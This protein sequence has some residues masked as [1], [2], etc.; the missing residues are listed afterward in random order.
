MRQWSRLRHLAGRLLAGSDGRPVTDEAIYLTETAYRNHQPRAAKAPEIRERHF[1]ADLR[2]GNR[3]GKTMD[4]AAA[5]APPRRGLLAR[6]G[7][8]RRLPAA[9][10][11]HGY[12]GTKILGTPHPA[13]KPEAA[14]KPEAEARPPA[15]S[16]HPAAATKPPTPGPATPPL[17]GDPPASGAPAP[18]GPQ[19]A[20]DPGD[21][22]KRKAPPS[23]A[24][25]ERTQPGDAELLDSLFG[26]P[27]EAPP[28]KPARP[29]APAPVK[30]PSAPA[31]A[32]TPA[33][34]SPAPARTGKKKKKKMDRGD[35]T[36]AVLGA[37]LAVT[38]ALFPW[39]IF[40]NQEKFG[41]RE[42]V[43]SG[44]GTARPTPGVAY[45][46][47]YI[48]KPFANAEVPKMELDFFPTATLPSGQEPVRAV[49]A[50]EQPF[51][52]DRVAFRLIHV[53]N[54]RAMIE[55]SDGLWV[56]QR[57]SQLP[58]ASR[59]AAIEQR[60][61]RWVLVTSDDRVVELAD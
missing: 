44:G 19:A 15:G 16:R 43:F 47:Q 33:K 55:D 23:P 36:M 46:P 6:L 13:C 26:K 53:A 5:H 42:F 57:G 56:V 50:S 8:G 10:G 12:F 24:K 7:I 17:A 31:S 1:G 11:E 30:Q 28:P 45:Q 59:V 9:A 21:G 29:A 27:D 4:E 3:G 41:V 35:V 34:P 54:G 32:A 25:S 20:T 39:Y 2:R 40:F 38:C 49:P 48:G 22:K 61:G 60:E 18:A 52:A 37:T 51:P 58:D 14:T